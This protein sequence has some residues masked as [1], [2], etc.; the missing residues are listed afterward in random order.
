MDLELLGDITF[1]TLSYRKNFDLIQ[2]NDNIITEIEGS[3]SKLRIEEKMT[4]EI[5]GEYQISVWDIRTCRIFDIN[6]NQLLY[7]QK[8]VDI[9]DEAIELTENDIL[10]IN[11]YNKVIFVHS[12]LLRDDY[13]NKEITQEFV[14]FLY[15]EYY[16]DKSIIISLVKP[17]QDNTINFNHYYHERYVST[18]ILGSDKKIPMKDYYKLDKLLTK[19][20]TEKNEYK[21]FSVASK[22]GMYR[23]DDYHHLF[24]L[25]P[26]KVIERM[27]NKNKIK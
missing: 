7:D 13:R 21:L 15:R 19:T 5:I 22:C 10:N 20:D 2:N 24:Y 14:E 6:P 3:V 27:Q 12:L 9:Y 17:F 16:F 25:K 1:K 8:G 23:F 18:N 4:P 11:N 26:N